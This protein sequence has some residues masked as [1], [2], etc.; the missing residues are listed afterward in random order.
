MQ[1]LTLTPALSRKRER[2]R[3]ETFINAEDTHPSGDRILFSRLREKVA[4]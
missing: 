3:A 1:R 2:G 4:L